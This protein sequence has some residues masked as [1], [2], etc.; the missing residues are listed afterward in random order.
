[1]S[2]LHEDEHATSGRVPTDDAGAGAAPGAPPTAAALR[3]AARRRAVGLVVL[4][5]AVSLTC[6]FLG[7]WQW[8][9]HVARDAA[10]AVVEAN[11]AAPPADLADVVADP[12]APLPEADAWRSVEVRGRYVPDAAVLLRNRP[13]VPGTPGY[14]VLVPLVVQDAAPGSFG[15]PVDAG[16]VLVVD[17]GWVP[18]GADGSVDV[19]V[20]APPAGDV[21]VTVRLRPGEP[22]S[23]RSAPDGQV[24]AIAPTQVLAAAGVDGE[25]YAA[26]GGLVREDPAADEPLGAL[27][28]PSTDPGSHLSYA[29][30]WW[31]FA[32]GG[33]VAFSV[34]ARREWVAARALGDAAPAPHPARPRRARGRDEIDEDAEIEAQQRRDLQA[35]ASAMRSR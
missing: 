3:A 12:D 28:A 10:I 1:M 33:L 30:Q 13:V 18:T 22:V 11:Y 16:R 14:H 34:A 21:T 31:V 17:R 15:A 6:T 35:Q 29:F 2:L 23:S 9:R 4:A 25:P 26:Y 24:Q 19:D 27:A 5:V 7:R 8:N 20:P 32:L